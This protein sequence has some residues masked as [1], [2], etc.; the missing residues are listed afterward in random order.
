MF[1]RLTGNNSI[2]ITIN[3]H[4]VSRVW[5]LAGDTQIRFDDGNVILVKDDYRTVEELLAAATGTTIH[6]P[7]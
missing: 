2:Q 7:E 3:A 6:L 5:P 1:I 4:H